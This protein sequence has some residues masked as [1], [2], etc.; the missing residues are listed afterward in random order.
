M[1]R[2][3]EQKTVFDGRIFDVQTG[4]AR[5]DDGT[6]AYREMVRHPG[7]VCVAP[8]HDGKV[9]L[10]RQFRIAV[11]DYVLELPAG[12][13]EGNEDPEFRGRAELAEETGYRAGRMVPVGFTYAS[14]GYCSERIHLYLA[15]DL[16]PVGQNLEFDEAIEVVE[17]P[18]DEVRR[19]LAT[20]AIPDA[21]TVVGLT[22]LFNHL[23]GTFGTP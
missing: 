22:R 21:K 23:D 18:L 6:V 8:L 14:V 10:I 19:R 16:E 3:I 9:I 7:G 4:E 5:M 15:F 20:N 1:E 2:W 12:K 11:D 13:L 17:M